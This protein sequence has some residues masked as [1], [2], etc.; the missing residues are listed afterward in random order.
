MKGKACVFC[1]GCEKKKTGSFYLTV[2][3]QD[4]RI[5]Y[6]GKRDKVTHLKIFFF[7]SIAFE[8]YGSLLLEFL[9][10]FGGWR[11]KHRASPDMNA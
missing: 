8:T 11:I 7:L 10:R 4:L 3:Q 9:R 6:Y 5:M 2:Q 1:L